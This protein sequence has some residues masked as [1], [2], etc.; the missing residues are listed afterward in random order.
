MR[1]SGRENTLPPTMH[2][3]QSESSAQEHGGVCCT[4]NVKENEAINSRFLK[5]HMNF[6][7][8]ELLHS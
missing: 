8:I 5:L 3:L 6:Q 2:E 7:K 4:V 1:C